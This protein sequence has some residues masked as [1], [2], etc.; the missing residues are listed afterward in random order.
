MIC[1]L[2]YDQTGDRIGCEFDLIGLGCDLI[3]C[4]L[5]GVRVP[6]LADRTGV[7]RVA[8]SPMRWSVVHS[9]ILGQ[10]DQA[11]VNQ[12]EARSEH[13]QAEK[14]ADIPALLKMIKELVHSTKGT[15]CSYWT[16]SYSLRRLIA[17]KQFKQESL[18][19]HCNRFMDLVNVAEA[20]WGE[21]APLDMILEA[22]GTIKKNPTDD[23]KKESRLMCLACACM[24]GANQQKHGGC[25]AELNNSFL[26][27]NDKFPKSPSNALEF[28]NNCM[29]GEQPSRQHNK[30]A[31]EKADDEMGEVNAAQKA[32]S[33]DQ[34][35]LNDQGERCIILPGGKKKLM[36]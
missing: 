30:K 24:A 5:V 4:D 3:G 8:V 22:D 20:Q 35:H 34:I 12:L 32:A 16:L 9:V 21:L 11:L 15:Q 18:T 1:C 10:C 23:E 28:L 25:I 17:I 36:W 26:S 19:A 29:T 31:E 7:H 2:C 27:G 13:K 14:D 33:A 6:L